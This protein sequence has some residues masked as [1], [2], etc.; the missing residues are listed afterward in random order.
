MNFIT[1]NLNGAQGFEIKLTSLDHEA[2]SRGWERIDLLKIDVQGHEPAVLEGASDLLKRQAI[3]CLFIEI[4]GLEPGEPGE[5]AL[6]LLSNA[7]YHFRPAGRPRQPFAA[8]GTWLQGIDDLVAMPAQ[9][10]KKT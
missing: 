6:R 7:G 1:P 5:K 9:S 10:L 2:H 3:S 8:P 4:N